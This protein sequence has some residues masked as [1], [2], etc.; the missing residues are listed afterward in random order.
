[1]K[2]K[3]ESKKNQC[4]FR[5]IAILGIIGMLYIGLFSTSPARAEIGTIGG[6]T[7][8]ISLVLQALFEDKEECKKCHG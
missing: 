4:F 2:R 7:F 8:L 5:I 6:I 1:M 3:K